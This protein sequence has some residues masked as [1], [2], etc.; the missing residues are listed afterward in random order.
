LPDI[1]VNF[2]HAV[3]QCGYGLVPIVE[4]GFAQGK[5]GRVKLAVQFFLAASVISFAALNNM[6]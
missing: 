4:K 2:K 3:V 1:L 6:E 5:K